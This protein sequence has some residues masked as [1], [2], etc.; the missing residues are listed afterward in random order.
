[1]A[2]ESDLKIG[3]KFSFFFVIAA[4]ISQYKLRITRITYIREIAVL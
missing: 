3:D 2:N 1:M 4:K